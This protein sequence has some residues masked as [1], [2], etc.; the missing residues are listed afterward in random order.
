MQRILNVEAYSENIKYVED[1][2]ITDPVSD[3]EFTYVQ[4]MKLPALGGI[5]V[6]LHMQ[7]LGDRGGYRVV[8]WTQDDPGTQ[9]LDKKDGA[10]TAYN[11][12]AWLI[13]PNRACVCV[14]GGAGEE[15]CR[16]AQVRDHDQG[17]G[18]NC[19]DGSFF[20]H[21]CHGRMGATRLTVLAGRA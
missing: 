7:D 14:I 6:S 15:G 19:R 16:V 21:R 1:C 12:G 11:L 10:R 17:L 9:A 13:K 8:A 20:Q 4:R 5:Q 3:R 2:R 18:R